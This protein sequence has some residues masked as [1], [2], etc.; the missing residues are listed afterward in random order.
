MTCVGL[1]FLSILG[2][3]S[4][5]RPDCTFYN[6]PF[7][8]RNPFLLCPP[9]TLFSVPWLAGCPVLTVYS[10]TGHCAPFLAFFFSFSASNLPGSIFLCP[11]PSFST[12]A[13]YFALLILV[14]RV[15]PD[16]P[17]LYLALSF[18]FFSYYAFF[19]FQSLLL[20]IL[21]GFPP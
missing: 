17:L 16:F 9:L 7:F 12:S 1:F 4:S 14:F 6:G 15:L 10:P 19:D 5:S 20:F 21:S 8:A 11:Y 3:L 2:I 18:F 13:R